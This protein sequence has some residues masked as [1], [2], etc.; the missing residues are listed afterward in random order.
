MAYIGRDPIYGLFEKQVFTPNGV[1]TSFIL[2]YLVGSAGSVLV[3]QGGV[4]RNPDVDYI[5]NDGGRT[6]VFS[7]APSSSFYV[8]Y[9]G[10]QFLV[11]SFGKRY[12]VRSLSDNLTIISADLP[13]ILSLEP[14]AA[15]RTV[16]IPV[17]SAVAGYQLII[18]NRSAT[19]DIIVNAGA[20]VVTVLPN[21]NATIVSD[22]LNW[23]TV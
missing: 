4:V 11:P 3:V 9:L 10:K 22:S 21:T 15:S 18:R 17:A 14:L 5:I 2:D 13:D 6:I 23:F 16:F 20:N 1:D 19:N 12:I 7:T 8:L